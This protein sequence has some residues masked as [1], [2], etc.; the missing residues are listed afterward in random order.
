[1]PLPIQE[2]GGML[3]GDIHNAID[4]GDRSVR[5]E[6]RNLLQLQ[7][8]EISG[9][10]ERLARHLGGPVLDGH[11]PDLGDFGRFVQETK[12]RD[13]EQKGMLEK[14]LSGQEADRETARARESSRILD[15]Q[16]A[17][18]SVETLKRDVDLLKAGQKGILKRFG[19]FCENTGPLAEFVTGKWGKAV[20]AAFGSSLVLTH[21]KDTL[22]HLKDV[23]IHIIHQ[24]T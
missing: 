23:L 7:S 10:K 22:T 2:Q 13:A 8:D 15:N 9:I 3:A 5:H 6:V 14:L 1:M 20:G 16:T 11:D 21:F 12:E 24:H 17:K 18:G 19:D 4:K